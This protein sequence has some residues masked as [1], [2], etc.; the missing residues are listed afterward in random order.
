MAPKPNPLMAALSSFK[1]GAPQLGDDQGEDQDQ[2]PDATDPMEDPRSASADG[3]TLLIDKDMFPGGCKVGDTVTIEATVESL[4]TKFGVVPQSI[5][6][7]KDD[8]GAG[9]QSQYQ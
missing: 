6:A 2:E 1:R 5:K 4:G 7:G 9:D 8:S 3:E